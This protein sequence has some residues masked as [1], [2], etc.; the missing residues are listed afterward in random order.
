MLTMKTLHELIT[1]LSETE[2]DTKDVCMQILQRKKV[3]AAKVTDE[4]VSDV[5]NFVEA[6]KEDFNLEQEDIDFLDDE[7]LKL[8]TS[9]GDDEDEDE[10]EDEDPTIE[11]EPEPA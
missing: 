7:L 11:D 4:L 9:V 1:T 2:E 8:Q 5:E 3:Q 6:L 10:D